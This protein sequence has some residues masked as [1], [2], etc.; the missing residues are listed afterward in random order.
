MHEQIPLVRSSKPPRGIYLGES[1]TMS[2]SSREG[3][4]HFLLDTGWQQRSPL[5]KFL[6]D[7]SPG[8]VVCRH[9]GNSE[10]R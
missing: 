9:E 8:G 7:K 1:L 3:L 10:L 6:F 2:T 4:L 5:N